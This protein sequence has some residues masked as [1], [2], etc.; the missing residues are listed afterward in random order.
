[1][2]WAASQALSGGK[3]TEALHRSA[4]TA[5]MLAQQRPFSCCAAALSARRRALAEELN[6]A[7][8]K[9]P[10]ATVQSEPHSFN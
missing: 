4:F 6:T 1:M 2:P 7:A 5:N 3:S 9:A 8:L 10:A